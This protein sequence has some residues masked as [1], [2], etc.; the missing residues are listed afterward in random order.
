MTYYTL[1]VELDEDI[2]VAILED[3]LEN[4]EQKPD[5]FVRALIRYADTHREELKA[6]GVLLLTPCQLES[7]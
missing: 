1:L 6:E 4:S 2:E 3:M 7:E 5:D